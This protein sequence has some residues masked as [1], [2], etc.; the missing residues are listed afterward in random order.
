MQYRRSCGIVMSCD[1][2]MSCGIVTSCGIV[3]SCGILMSC[4][5][6][7]RWLIGLCSQSQRHYCTRLFQRQV[8]HWNFNTAFQMSSVVFFFVLSLILLRSVLAQ[9]K[10]CLRNVTIHLCTSCGN[11]TSQC[12]R[13]KKV[14]TFA[15]FDFVVSASI[16]QW[17]RQFPSRPWDRY[18]R[19]ICSAFIFI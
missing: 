5:N 4:I 14:T 13:V 7:M 3:M 11:Y 15:A 17:P 12:Q 19:V 10:W 6:V 1:I 16:T 18:V 8:D 2:V 9:L